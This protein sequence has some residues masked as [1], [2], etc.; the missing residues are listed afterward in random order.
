MEVR[1]DIEAMYRAGKVEFPAYAEKLS[2]V[3]STVVEQTP[4]WSR[5]AAKAQSPA[6]LVKAVELNDKVSKLLVYA[7]QT[8]NDAAETV[9]AI[10]DDFVETDE[11]AAAEAAALQRQYPEIAGPFEPVEVP[12]MPEGRA[13]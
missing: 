11:R 5:E 13:Q 8:W 10:T 4:V 6:A 2:E 7:V 9:V 12:Q 3:A 1:A